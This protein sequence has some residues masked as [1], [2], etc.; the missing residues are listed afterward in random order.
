MEIK[1]MSGLDLAYN[2][3]FQ[4]SIFLCAIKRNYYQEHTNFMQFS[5]NHIW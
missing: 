5:N 2:T 3:I 4:H 1:G